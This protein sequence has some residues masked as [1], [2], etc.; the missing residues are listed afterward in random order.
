MTQKTKTPHLRSLSEGLPPFEGHTQYTILRIY[1]GG[2]LEERIE[3]ALTSVDH[4]LE[5]VRDGYSGVTPD[6]LNS[7]ALKKWKKNLQAYIEKQA[8][9]TVGR[10]RQAIAL[11]YFRDFILSPISEEREFELTECRR[12]LTDLYNVVSRPKFKI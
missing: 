11:A 3:T 9:P 1:A 2:D 12:Q 6:L 10:D 5:A 4:L 8:H 7:K